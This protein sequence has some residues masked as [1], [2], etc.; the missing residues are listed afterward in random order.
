MTTDFLRWFGII[1]KRNNKFVFTSALVREYP[2]QKDFLHKV[3][4]QEK[5]DIV[6]ELLQSSS[7]QPKDF[8]H[9]CNFH[10]VNAPPPKEKEVTASIS[11]YR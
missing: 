8:V 5:G 9:Y 6:I 10:Y 2:E 4:Q 11:Q 3:M 7:W 1:R